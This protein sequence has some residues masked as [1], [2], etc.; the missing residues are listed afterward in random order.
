MIR[1]PPISTR[2]YTR[3]PY[4]TLCRSI[5]ARRDVLGPCFQ[6]GFEQRVGVAR[7]RRIGDEAHPIEAVADRARRAEIAA[8]LRHRGAHVGDGAVAVVGQR[9]DDQRNAA[10]AEA[11]VAD[12]LV[13]LA[14][15]LRCLVDRALDIVI[16][17][18]EHTSEL[19]S[20]MSISDAVFCLN[21]KKEH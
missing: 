16:R 13:I 12:F 4:T 8:V 20:L 10:G 1:L 5:L 18:E 3:F 17:S 21:K 15:A 11:F 14:V 2:T 7:A 6:R 9:L 19:Q